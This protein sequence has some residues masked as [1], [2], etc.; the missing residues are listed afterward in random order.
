MK[1]LL[2]LSG[3]GGT[4]KTTVATALI[5]LFNCLSYAD[6]DVDTPNLHLTLNHKEVYD[7]KDYYGLPKAYIDTDKCISCN[8]C[9]EH[10]RF[11][12]IEI[13]IDTYRVDP[14]SCEGC[15][16]CHF[17]CP[18]D[19][20]SILPE[21]SGEL[22]LY[23]DDD[24]TF[25]T[26]QLKIGAGNSGLL[27]TSVKTRL[28]EQ[29]LKGDLAILDG[30]PGIG[31][32]VIASLSGV[33]LALIVTE[34]SLTGIS[35]MKRILKTAEGFNV[36]CCVIINKYDI[37]EENS[38]LIREYLKN[39]NIPFLGQIPYDTEAV[40]AVNKGVSIVHTATKAGDALRSMFPDIKNMVLE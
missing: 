32:P 3:K 6:C 13:I 5:E 18:H 12:A 4:G 19:A 36:K 14:I 30:S 11:D 33:D 22:M 40:N 35:D 34:P 10:C 29:D 15:G 9:Y 2:V 20:V 38:N 31:C 16:V 39:E 37:N 25:S 21:K 17:V 27:V 8:L 7:F 1:K 28:F 26:A 24:K 23:K